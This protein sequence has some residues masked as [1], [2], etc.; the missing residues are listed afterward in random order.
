MIKSGAVKTFLLWS[1]SADWYAPSVAHFLPT[2]P[3][4]YLKDKEDPPVTDPMVRWFISNALEMSRRGA[5]F[6][7]VQCE[8]FEYLARPTKE[9][10]PVAVP[11]AFVLV[12]GEAEKGSGEQITL[13]IIRY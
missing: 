11:M 7:E 3:G 4:I 5:Y 8:W 10:P 13:Y 12:Q 2:T 1:A 9:L 6:T